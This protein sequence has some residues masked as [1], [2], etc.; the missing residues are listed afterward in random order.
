MP[1]NDGAAR[2]QA[3]ILEPVVVRMKDLGNRHVAE[4]QTG[5]EIVR[6]SAAG[7]LLDLG[8]D[9]LR[10]RQLRAGATC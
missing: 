3:S 9:R 7:D 1:I 8:L 5:I 10:Q 4:R 6:T 2:H